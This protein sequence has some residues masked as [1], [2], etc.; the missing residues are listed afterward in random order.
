MPVIGM[1]AWLRS[2]RLSMSHRVAANL[3]MAGPTS[4]A[5]DPAPA[6]RPA[7]E[8]RPM[9]LLISSHPPS[10]A[11]VAAAL[12]EALPGCDCLVF[13]TAQKALEKA[14]SARH[15]GWSPAI[16]VFDYRG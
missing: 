12:H 4:P 16:F 10:L 15:F 2:E 3:Q 8:R 14:E 13:P 5:P 11:E 1:L 7:G 6:P 9:S